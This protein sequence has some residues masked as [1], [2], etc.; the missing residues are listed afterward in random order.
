MNNIRICFRRI[1]RWA[2]GFVARRTRDAGLTPSQIQALRHITY[3]GTMSQQE[4]VEDMG[5]DKAAV[6]RLVAGLEERGYVTRTADPKDG[7]AKLISATESAMQVKDDVV[8][9]EEAYYSWL[10]E[11]LTPEER[12]CFAGIMERLLQRGREGRRSCY[13]ELDQQR[14]EE[15]DGSCS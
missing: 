8:A 14:Q 13:Q 15:R 12:A 3:H 7:R 10:L 11:E 4:L 5:V 9:L 2:Q 1:N 6:T